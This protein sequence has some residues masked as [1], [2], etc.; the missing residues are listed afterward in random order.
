[1]GR[2]GA[3]AGESIGIEGRAGRPRSRGWRGALRLVSGIALVTWLARLLGV[4]IGIRRHARA[5]I[6]P[7]GMTVD[8]ELG[9]LGKRVRSSSRHLALDGVI[10]ARATARYG[11]ATSL[12]GAIALAAGVWVGGVTFVDGART[13]ETFLLLAG[14]AMIAVGAAIDLLIDVI[15][16]AGRAHARVELLFQD[17][18]SLA[19]ESVPED[20]AHAFL[21]AVDRARG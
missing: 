18:T 4:V 16:P 6:G 8:E 13:G 14:A 11:G 9:W 2:T 10:G 5:E 19:I 21:H 1:M 17:G 20:D 15:L 3:R 12:A 7:T